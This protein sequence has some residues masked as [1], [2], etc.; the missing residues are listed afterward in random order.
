MD[1]EVVDRLNEQYL[2][3]HGRNLSEHE[4]KTLEQVII[5]NEA[6]AVARPRDVAAAMAAIASLGFEEKPKPKLFKRKNVITGA[7]EGAGGHGGDTDKQRRR[8]QAQIRAE[9]K[10]QRQAKK[11]GR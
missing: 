11:K 7:Y 9:R 8:T 1:K 2:A 6:H 5:I 10:R 3:Q 4:R